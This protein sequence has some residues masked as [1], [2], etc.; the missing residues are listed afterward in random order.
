MK[1]II[2]DQ[3][4]SSEVQDMKE[5]QPHAEGLP[6]LGGRYDGSLDSPL[7]PDELSGAPM[8]NAPTASFWWHPEENHRIV[9][10]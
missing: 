5:G 8:A 9:R 3:Q 10:C 4:V 6:S 1:T 2:E 7:P